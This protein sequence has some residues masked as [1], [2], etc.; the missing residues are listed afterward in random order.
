MRYFQLNKTTRLLLI[1]VL[2]VVAILFYQLFKEKPRVQANGPQVT[3]GFTVEVVA[4][5]D[6]VDYPM[7][8]TL[9]ETGR[10]FVF[11][12]TGNIYDK[13]EDAIR[14]PQFRIRLLQD[15]DADGIYDSSTIFADKLSFPQG[16]VFYKGSLYASSDRK[17]TRLNSSHLVI[18]YAVF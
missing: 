14:D 5:P 17:S 12:S 7:F 13:S 4:G 9:D 18:S 11:E 2:L 3:S 15:T 10:L 16:G 1:P 8:S 6:M